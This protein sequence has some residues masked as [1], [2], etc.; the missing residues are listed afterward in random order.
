M[1]HACSFAFLVV[2]TAAAVVHAP[3]NKAPAAR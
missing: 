2:L 1:T 3:R